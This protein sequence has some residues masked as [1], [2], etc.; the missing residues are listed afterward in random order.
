[1]NALGGMLRKEALH[2]LRDR[3]TLAI[4]LLMPLVQVLLF[5]FAIRTEVDEIRLAVVDPTPD[6]VTA[7]I[8]NR[9]RASGLFSIVAEH[10]NTAPLEEL[11]ERGAARQALVFESG[12]GSRIGRGGRAQ[13]LVITDATDPNTGMVM[14]ADALGVLQ[15]YVEEVRGGEAAA[16]IRPEVRLR[17]NPTLESTHL[18]VP[19]L[20]AFV[21][22]IVSAMTTALSLTREKEAGTMELLLVSP[23]RPPQVIVGKVLPYLV[24]G[25]VNVLSTLAVA[26]LV[27]RVPQRGSWILL[28]AES[29]LFI[30]TALALGVLIST[31]TSSQRVA[32]FAALAGLMMPTVLLS[33]FIFPIESM[34]RPLQLLSNVIPARWF[35]LIVR[36]IMLK[37]VGLEYLWQETAVLALMTLLLL[38]AG[39][40]RFNVRLG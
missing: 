23:V 21:L 10:P 29:L 24:L 14:Q 38:G 39:A 4:L 35:V 32:M 33:G 12:F 3:R 30:L 28:L 8:R 2:L 37:G 20:I 11:F 31:R 19:G 15:R 7:E 34:P 40:R 6:A 13:V 27:F 5:G 26:R 9:L 25:F 36:G 17:F 1:M 22:T 18:F 16:S